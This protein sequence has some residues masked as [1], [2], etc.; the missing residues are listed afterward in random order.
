MRCDQ[1]QERLS[2][3]LEDLLDAESHTSVHDHLSSCPHCQAEAQ[4]LSQTRQAVADLPSVEP[5]PGFSQRVMSR[6]REES[7][8]PNLWH[9]LF[10]PLRIKIPIHAMAILLVGG[11]AVYLYQVNKPV[12]TEVA[13][14][15]PSEPLPPASIEIHPQP[16]ASP[17]PRL[18]ERR[19][20]EMDE[21]TATA[22]GRRQDLKKGNKP[23]DRGAGILQAEKKS[24]L[25]AAGKSPAEEMPA[26][27][28]LAAP[29]V[30]E[31]TFTPNEPTE[32]MKVLAPKLKSLVQKLGGVYLSPTESNDTLK[33]D[34]LLKPQTIWLTIPGD[35]FGQFKTELAALGK[36][37]DSSIAQERPAGPMATP[38]PSTEVP[39]FLRIKLTLQLPEKQK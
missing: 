19:A 33:Q 3:Y 35:R 13:F 11:L 14:M 29:S 5:P 10:L 34:L 20:R 36:V 26:R 8:R 28:P 7:E 22:P 30:R 32:G 15:K 31:L 18:S 2:E 38:E 37:Q 39:P 16:P 17:P 6:V 4:A 12:Q 9:R 1:V 21:I 27:K 25:E 23:A 24:K